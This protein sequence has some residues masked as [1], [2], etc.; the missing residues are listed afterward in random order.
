MKNYQDIHKQ[1]INTVPDNNIHLIHQYNPNTK[2]WK[3]FSYICGK[4]N[5][6]LKTTLNLEKHLK[7]CR[8]INKTVVNNSSK[9]IDKY[10]NEWTQLKL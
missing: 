9:I 6:P 8:I 10:G 2:N 1:I 4:C 5:Q 3:F 7:T